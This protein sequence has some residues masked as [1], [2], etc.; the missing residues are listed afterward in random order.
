M[1]RVPDVMNLEAKRVLQVVARLLGGQA[2]H[3]GCPLRDVHDHYAPR[4]REP[5]GQLPQPVSRWH[6]VNAG[7]ELKLRKRANVAQLS[8][9]DVTVV[10]GQAM[11]IAHG[12]RSLPEQR[13]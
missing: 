13:R 5:L 8:D 7:T 6:A 11:R 10:V 12:A 4:L 2:G 3:H 9:A 1:V